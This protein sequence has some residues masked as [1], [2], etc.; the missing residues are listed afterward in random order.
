MI[1]SCQKSQNKTFHHS[2]RNVEKVV[3][4]PGLELDDSERIGIEQIRRMD[5]LHALGKI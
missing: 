5:S 3:M 2:Q 4:K 1:V